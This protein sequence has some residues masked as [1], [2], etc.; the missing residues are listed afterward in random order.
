MRPLGSLFCALVLSLPFGSARAGQPLAQPVP[1]EVTELAVQA[2]QQ[3]GDVFF[4]DF[5]RCGYGQLHLALTFDPVAGGKLSVRLGEKLASDGSLDRQP[6]GSVNYRELSLVLEPGKREYVLSLPTKQRHL[7]PEAVPAPSGIGEITPFRYVE[8]E[9]LGRPL[10]VSSLHQRFVHAPF[11]DHA[12]A[13]ECSDA[14][15]NA[16]WEL[17]RHTMKASSAFGLYID[18]ERERIAYEADAYIN[19]LSHYACDLDP[20]IARA[21]VEHLLKFPTWPTEWSLHMPMMAAAD[22]R[23]TGDA[24]LARRHFDALKAK[25]L[26]HKAR[27]DGLLRADAI[28][29]WPAG[30]RDG[31]NEGKPTK[32]SRE[33]GPEINTVV[34]AFY[35]HALREMALLAKAIGRDAEGLELEREAVRV[36]DSFNRVFFDGARGVYVDGEGCAHVSLHANLFPLAFG[37]VPPEHTKGVADFV[38]SKGMACSVYAAQ[39]LLEALYAADRDEAALALMSS[40]GPRSWWHMMEMGSTMTTE[41]WDASVKKNL[42]WNHP[43]GAAPANVLSR[44]VLGVR[45]LSPGYRDLLVA[46]RLGGLAWA[47]GQVPTP[48]GPVNLRIKDAQVYELDLVLPPVARTRVE[49]PRR[50]QGILLVDGR[51]LSATQEGRSLVV[52]LTTPGPHHL[53]SR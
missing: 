18:G 41:A 3:R 48:F 25:L 16:V 20:R 8:I 21:T 23:A 28:V 42:T 39:Y 6:P 22:Y 10:D 53:E 44:F 11:D 1:L 52:I 17:C 9:G 43:W 47:N 38:Q 19:Q 24:V 30:E 40:R 13:F 5:G 27:E 45:P 37:L 31:Y 32:D 4:A 7:L 14:T 51:P 12:A 34:N 46:P 36:S 49:L 15:L 50:S 33:V 35:V 26:R 29:D 2:S